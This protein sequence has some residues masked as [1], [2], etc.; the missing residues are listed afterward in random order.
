V[1]HQ[2]AE[3]L[4]HPPADRLGNEPLLLR[5]ALDDLDVDARLAAVLDGF[6]LEALV[7][8]GLGDGVGAGRDPERVCQRLAERSDSYLPTS[9]DVTAGVKLK[10]LAQ[11]PEKPETLLTPNKSQSRP[12]ADAMASPDTQ[13]RHTTAK[14]GATPNRQRPPGRSRRR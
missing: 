9:T 14:P 8:R 12:D 2:D 6:G 3:G 1:E 7:D 10:D 13:Q 5:V 4:L 11:A